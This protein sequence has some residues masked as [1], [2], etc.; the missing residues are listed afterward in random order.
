MDVPPQLLGEPSIEL[1]EP[2]DAE[3]E[4]A[5][6][7]RLRL[8]VSAGG[9]VDR[10][11]IEG[12]SVQ[13]AYAEALIA[14]FLPLRFGPGEIGGVAVNGQVVFEIDIDPQVPGTSRASDSK[15]SM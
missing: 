9:T 13:S 15:G 12:D 6:N 8:F 3:A 10:A 5:G 11:E 14:A 2:P 7:L 4:N 1:P